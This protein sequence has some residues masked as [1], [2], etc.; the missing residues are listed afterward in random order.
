MAVTAIGAVVGNGLGAIL[1]VV[2]A[3][4][5]V[6]TGL[7]SGAAVLVGGGVATRVAVSVG[8]V[9]SVAAGE[10]VTVTDG[11]GVA[12]ETG[13]CAVGDPTVVAAC[14]VG[15]GVTGLPVAP[16]AVTR[17]AKPTR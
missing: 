17:R 9:V 5:V 4:V 13:G 14:T 7:G 15:E 16:R 2:G 10:A 11:S 1:V 8:A 3:K 6:G 12:L